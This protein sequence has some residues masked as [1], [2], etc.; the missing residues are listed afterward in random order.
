[1]TQDREP[2]AENVREALSL[3]LCVLQSLID[4]KPA[5]STMHIWAKA[6]EA[7]CKVRTLLE[8]KR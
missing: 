8:T 1:M 2:L 7:E 4:P 3:S 6:V 5:E